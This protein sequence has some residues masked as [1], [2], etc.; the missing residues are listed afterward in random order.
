MHQK[1]A[2]F[3]AKGPVVVGSHNHD[4]DRRVGQQFDGLVNRM[5]REGKTRTLDRAALRRDPLTTKVKSF[6]LDTVS[7]GSAS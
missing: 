5:R 1:L 6:F 3:G 2:R 7:A 4:D